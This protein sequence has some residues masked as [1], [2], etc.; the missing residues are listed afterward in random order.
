MRIF[1]LNYCELTFLA[2]KSGIY[3]IIDK[4]LTKMDYWLYW[5]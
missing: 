1:M 4:V 2:V 3:V 5:R